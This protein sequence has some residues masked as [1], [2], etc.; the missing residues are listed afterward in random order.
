MYTHLWFRQSDLDGIELTGMVP[1]HPPLTITESSLDQQG[2]ENCVH[3]PQNLN[4]TKEERE[5][6]YQCALEN[7]SVHN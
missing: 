2:E 3:L 6:K 1:P 4:M 5:V 7:H